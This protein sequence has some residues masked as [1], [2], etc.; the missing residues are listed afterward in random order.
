MLKQEVSLQYARGMV[1]ALLEGIVLR[2]AA[3][4]VEVHRLRAA[5]AA[6]FFHPLRRV[7][8]ATP[9]GNHMEKLPA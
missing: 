5:A 1:A 9:P 2:A 6:P 3:L 7:S 8:S 4:I